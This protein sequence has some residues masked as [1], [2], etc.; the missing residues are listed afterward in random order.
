[1]MGG[2]GWATPGSAQ[3]PGLTEVLPRD[4]EMRA[5]LAAAPQ[6]VAEGA[7]IWVL[8]P[9]GYEEARPTRNGFACFVMRDLL[10]GAPPERQSFAPMCFDAEG[11]RTILTRYIARSALVRSDGMSVAEADAV[12]DERRERFTPTRPGITYMASAMNIQPDPTAPRGPFRTYMPHVMFLAPGLSDAQISAGAL[13]AD[14][15]EAFY[16]GW[17]FLPGQARPD[18]FVVVPLDRRLRLKIQEEQSD[19]VEQLSEWIPLREPVDL[20]GE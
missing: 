5:A 4:F 3:T 10:G 12:L 15:E 16:G 14:P 13:R 8:G 9:E 6:K 1:M 2:L 20:G 7:G 11:A 19:L 18:G 17:P